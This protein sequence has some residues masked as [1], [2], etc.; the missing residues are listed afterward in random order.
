MKKFLLALLLLPTIA[1]ADVN[2]RVSP[3]S[4][5]VGGYYV[6]LDVPVGGAWTLGPT[7]AFLNSRSD[8]FDVDGFGAGIRGNYFFAGE[9]FK[10][11]WYF[12]PAVTYTK[13]R[14]EDN[15]GGS[16]GKVEGEGSGIAFS[17]L[18]GYHW[19][20]E[21]FNLNLGLGPSYLTMDRIRV[22]NSQNNYREDYS[23]DYTGFGVTAEFTIGWRF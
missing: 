7:L 17:A 16:I 5:L 1:L 9:A 12:G 20:W 18:F 22:K 21:H 11:G 10:Q 6:E 13:V 2:L 19:F 4:F 23:G 8:G 14:V 15:F 3:L